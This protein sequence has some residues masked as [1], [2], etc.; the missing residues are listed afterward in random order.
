MR[1]YNLSPSHCGAPTHFQSNC[2]ARC[3]DFI[4]VPQTVRAEVP[5][6]VPSVSDHALLKVD[7][8]IDDDEFSPTSWKTIPWRLLDDVRL[9]N[10]VAA[11]SAIWLFL[12]LLAAPPQ[13]YIGALNI[14]W[15]ES[16]SRSSP[17]FASP[18]NLTSFVP[19]ST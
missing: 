17:A 2:R 6:V 7:L 18:S 12:S 15:S 16:F 5:E 9:D 13:G 19:L 11:A 3:I 14:M 4:F 1:K 8:R 10:F